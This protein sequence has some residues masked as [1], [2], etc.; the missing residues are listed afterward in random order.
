MSFFYNLAALCFFGAV[1]Q[2]PYSRGFYTHYCFHVRVAH[3]CK[4]KQ[5]ILAAVG[6]CTAVNQ[7][8]TACFCGNYRADCRTADALNTLYQKCCAAHNRTGA[9]GGNKGIALALGKELKPRHY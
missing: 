9:S 6:I 3:H 5:K 2:K 4:L 1:A 8:S 7:K